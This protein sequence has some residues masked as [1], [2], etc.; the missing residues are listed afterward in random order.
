VV[1]VPYD[2]PKMWSKSVPKL[3]CPVTKWLQCR[4]MTDV[5]TL[6]LSMVGTL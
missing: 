1:L 2:D 6:A 4:D 3:V 5:Q